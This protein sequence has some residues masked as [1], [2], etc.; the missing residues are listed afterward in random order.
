MNDALVYWVNGLLVTVYFLWAIKFALIGLIL[1]LIVALRYTG[2]VSSTGGDLTLRYNRGVANRAWATIWRVPL[3]TLAVWFI[4]ALLSPTDIEKVESIV[5]W[6]VLLAVLP[7]IP[8]ER[9]NALFRH[10][11]MMAVYGLM[12]ATLRLIIGSALELTQLAHLIQIGNTS[13]T[14]FASMRATLTPVMIFATWA[15]YPAGFVGLLVQRMLVN[16]GAVNAQGSPREVMR[17]YVNR[18]NDLPGR[19]RPQIPPDQDNW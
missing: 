13:L 12:M 17:Q 8:A 9:A 10:Q 1:G 3:L 7:G 5:M 11:T 16:R 18:G 6:S 2:E 4:G 15:L 19:N 14:A